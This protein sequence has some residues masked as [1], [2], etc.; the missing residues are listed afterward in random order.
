MKLFHLSDLHLGKRVYEF[1]MIDDQKFILNQILDAAAREKPDAVLI[2]GDIYDKSVPPAEAVE[3][4]DGFL[5]ELAENNTDVFVISGNHDSAGRIAFGSRLMER[6]GVHIARAYDGQVQCCA[7]EDPLGPVR[8]Y[9]LPFLRPA[10]VRRFFPDDEIVTYNDALRTAVRAIAPDKN[11]R[12]V[13][14]AHQFVTGASRS[15]SEDI[16]VGGIDNVDVSVFDDFDYVALGHIHSPQNIRRGTLRYCGTPLKYS[17]SEAG[18]VKSITVVELGEKSG[19]RKASGGAAV[20]DEAADCS[21]ARER[22]VNGDGGVE[23]DGCVSVRTL[24]LVPEH[25]L[26]EIRGSFEELTERSYY[27]E[28]GYDACYLHITLTDE[29]EI[30]DAVGRLRI[31]YPLL[32]KLDYDNARTRRSAVIDVDERTEDQ[33]PGELFEELFTKQNNRE[34]SQNQKKILDSL[35]EKIWDGDES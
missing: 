2:S 9:L 13:L 3:L 28:R 11:E 4:F 16:S 15:E 22:S 32:M 7:M 31:I 30:P 8:I 35:I 20:C 34:M 1:S 14:L 26:I 29:D 19:R 24:P 27:Q 5:T 6:S 17:F 12:N 10:D 25:D 18:Q 23:Q 21:E 33:L